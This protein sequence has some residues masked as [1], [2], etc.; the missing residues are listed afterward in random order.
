MLRQSRE[1]FEVVVCS[2]DRLQPLS[3][4]SDQITGVIVDFQGSTTEI[5]DTGAGCLKIKENVVY[6]IKRIFFLAFL[7]F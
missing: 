6:S 5:F 3:P 2:F 1:G 4:A 7:W